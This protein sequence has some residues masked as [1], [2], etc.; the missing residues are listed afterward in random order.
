M[1][2]NDLMENLMDS[3]RLCIHWEFLK[4]K[5]LVDEFVDFAQE[6]LKPKTSE[7]KA[8]YSEA[9]KVLLENK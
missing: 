4:K 2:D 1:K 6:D 7:E 3:R 8:I 5:G 9:I